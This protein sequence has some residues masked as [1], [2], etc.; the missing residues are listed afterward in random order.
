MKQT[1]KTI[2]ALTGLW[3]AHNF[4]VNAQTWNLSGNSNIATTDFLGTSA[5]GFFKD[6]V[7]KT[8]GVEK[9]RVL[10]GGN[11]G[12]GTITP[13]GGLLHINSGSLTPLYLQTSSGNTYMGSLNSSWSHFM[14]DRPRFY[15]NTGISVASGNIGSYTGNLSLQTSGTTRIT[16]LNSNGNVG[17]NNTTPTQM[18]H[19][20]NGAILIQG[21][22]AGGGPMVLLGGSST[23]ATVGEYGMEYDPNSF[24]SDFG[25]QGINFWKPTG[26]HRGNGTDGFANYILFLNNDGNIGMGVTPDKINA[27]YKLSVNGAIRA[28]KVVVEIG[29]AD[30]V[31]HK[32]YK[33]MPLN[34]L[35][36]FV[37]ANKH[38]PNIPTSDEIKE[39]GL[40]VGDVQAKQM[41]KIEE[42][43]LY[44]IEM[45]KK[46]QEQNQQLVELEKAQGNK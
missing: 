32:D 20:N 17:I 27:A 24:P 30:Y 22:W 4:S 10:S 26:S 14:T 33:L 21:N 12:I 13:T 3:L 41:E 1:L 18:L 31:F 43:T 2:T 36:K 37:N 19:I 25:K 46:I 44:I 5:T 45:N 29:W 15:F 7:I 35:E 23:S 34:E 28:T 40:D 38:L 11:V 16:V 42:L 8:N 6:L 39:K 9:M